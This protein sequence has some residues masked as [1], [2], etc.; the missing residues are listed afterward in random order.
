MEKRIESFLRQVSDELEDNILPFWL[1]LKDPSGGFYGEADPDG[2]II[3]DAPRGGILYSRII[4]SFAAAYRFLGR[5]EYLDAALHASC[6]FKEYLVDR[7][8]GG[9]FWSV[10]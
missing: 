10:T 7:E 1:S 6:W 3:P 4:W 8:Y 5:K 2:R 9:V